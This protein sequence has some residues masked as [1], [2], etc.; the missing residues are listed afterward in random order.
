MGWIGPVVNGQEHE[1]GGSRIRRRRPRR[2][3]HQRPWVLVARQPDDGPRDGERVRLA[4]SDDCTVEG[5]WRWA[6]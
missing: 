1:L 4:Y 5:V 6:S 2:R 3:H